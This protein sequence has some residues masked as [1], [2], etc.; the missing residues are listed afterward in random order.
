MPSLGKD[1]VKIRTHLGLTIQ[2]IQYATKIPV[3]TLAKI[4][5]DTIFDQSEEGTIYI[6]SFVRSYG[7]ALNINEALMI[8]ALDQYEAGTYQN[9]LIQNYFGEDAPD[10]KPGSTGDS[11]PDAKSD[12]DRSQTPESETYREESSATKERSP[13]GED[14]MAS[15]PDREDNDMK[16]ASESVSKSLPAAGNEAKNRP[17]SNFNPESRSSNVDWAKMGHPVTYDKRPLSLWIAGLFLLVIILGVAGYFIVESDY[18]SGSDRAEEE[19]TTPSEESTGISLNR[20][21]T[22]DQT[23]DAEAG[24]SEIAL[25]ETLYITVYAA[26]GNADP[27]RVWSDLKPRP[28]PYWLNTGT[29]MNFEFRDE[30]RVRGPMDN[31]LLFMNGHLI[32]NPTDHFYN[33]ETRDVELSRDYFVSSP[34]WS[35]SVSLRLPEGVAEPDTFVQRLV[36]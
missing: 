6:R 20:G 28:D 34:V 35:D 4:E 24:R 11:L 25:N 30:I 15:Q 31:I 3:H 26:F 18:F 22:D 8:E 33:E 9:L 23:A 12:G 5:D 16:S 2:D 13:E 17:A 36:F 10:V 21:S 1:L 32:E 19:I 14:R 29:A 7:R 27:V